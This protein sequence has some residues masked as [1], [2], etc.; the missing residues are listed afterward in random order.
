MKVLPEMNQLKTTNLNYLHETNRD[1]PGVVTDA[2]AVGQQFL[3]FKLAGEEYGIN[4]TRVQEIKGWLPVTKIPNT[5]DYVSGVL[6]LRGNIVPVMD[7][8]IRFNLEKAEYSQNTVI[9]VLTVAGNRNVGI[10][11]D[12]VSDVLNVN[13]EEIKDAPDFGENIKVDMI[14]GLTSAGNNLVMLMDIDQLL[15]DDE[16]ELLDSRI[17]GSEDQ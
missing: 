2:E 10:I 7:M 12:A 11:V 13:K 6:N 4:I 9:I 5:P 15:L 16:M 17:K 3:T 14:S 8:R 1:E